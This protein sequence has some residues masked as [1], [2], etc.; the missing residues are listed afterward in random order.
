MSVPSMPNP[1]RFVQY[2][3]PEHDDMA[4]YVNAGVYDDVS[5][6]LHM[7]AP[8]DEV[9]SILFGKERITLECY[10]VESLE[11]LRDLTEEEA[12]RLREAI[13]MNERGDAAEGDAAADRPGELVG[14]GVR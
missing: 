4:L 7:R 8:D 11:R 2:G 1:R 5:M 6:T 14:G 10:D 3:G 12:R 13:E 9:V